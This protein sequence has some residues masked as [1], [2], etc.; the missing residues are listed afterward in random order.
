MI[1]FAPAVLAVA[2]VAL[3]DGFRFEIGNPVAAQDFVAKTAAFAFRT[4]GC[5]DP[6]KAQVSATAEGLVRGERRSAEAKIA[7]MRRPGVYAVY[8]TGEWGNEGRWV[9]VLKGVCGKETAGAIVPMGRRDFV[10]ESAK[11][12]PRAA[13]AAEIEASLKDLKEGDSK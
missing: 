9:V 7:T 8:Q 1:R 10:R 13:T 11:F 5:A 2:A 12:F 4:E 3:A 6:A